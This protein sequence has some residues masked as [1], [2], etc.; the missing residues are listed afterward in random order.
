[1]CK[2]TTSPN[3]LIHTPYEPYG[4][5]IK[6]HASAYNKGQC[7]S[8]N[9]SYLSYPFPYNITGV[10]S[11]YSKAVPRHCAR[12]AGK[13]TLTHRQAHLRCFKLRA[14]TCRECTR[15]TMWP[16][17][18]KL[19]TPK[20]HTCPAGCEARVALDTF[21]MRPIMLVFSSWI[22]APALGFKWVPLEGWQLAC[23]EH[24]RG[25]SLWKCRE[26]NLRSVMSRPTRVQN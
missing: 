15:P 6:Y 20:L 1:M 4:P 23:C 24:E 8:I 16:A 25:D 17:S 10:P 2:P 14:R 7:C 5:S 9:R 13:H 18:Q 22:E 21:L 26:L 12:T 19:A 11:G 3:T